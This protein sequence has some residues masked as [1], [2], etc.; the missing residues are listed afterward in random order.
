[1]IHNVDAVSAE[2]KIHMLRVYTHLSDV[3]VTNTNHAAALEEE[4]L[5]PGYSL[6]VRDHWE[7]K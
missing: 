2:A 3:L 4:K 1:M 7:G 5:I 6:Q